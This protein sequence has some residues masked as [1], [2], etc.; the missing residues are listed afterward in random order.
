MTVRLVEKNPNTQIHPYWED[1]V[2]KT[3]DEIKNESNCSIQ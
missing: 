3:H 1:F 2:N